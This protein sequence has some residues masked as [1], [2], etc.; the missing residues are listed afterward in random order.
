MFLNGK[1][2]N[3][4]IDTMNIEMEKII[5]WLKTNKLSLNLKKT[6]YIL[7]RKRRGNVLLSKDLKMSN[8]VNF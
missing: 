2:P 4:L 6:H 5:T 1:D 3:S 8:T 7:F